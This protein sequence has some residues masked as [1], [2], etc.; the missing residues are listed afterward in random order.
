MAWQ[1]DL[2]PASFRGVPFKVENHSNTSG[3]RVTFHEFPNR[4]KPY[5]EDLGKVGE[6]FKIDGYLIGDDIKTQLENMKRAADAYGAAE[7]VHPRLGTLTVQCGPF[8]WEENKRDGRM[9]KISFQFYEGGSNAFPNSIEN[10]QDVLNDKADIA[11]AT[12]KASFD[13]K[14]SIDGLPGFAVD[15]ARKSVNQAADAF[16]N[17]TKGLAQKSDQISALAYNIRNLQAEADDLLQSPSALSQRLQDS[18]GLLQSALGSNKEAYQAVS[19]MSNFGTVTEPAPFQTPTRIAEA[20][21]LKAFDDFMKQTATINAA[22][23]A[24]VTEFDSVEESVTAREQIVES[25]E[26]QLLTTTDDDVFAAL[27]DVKAQVVRVLPDQDAELP[28]VQSYNLKATTPAIVV[29]YDLFENVDSE[30]DLI[31]RNKVRNPAFVLGGKELEVLDVRK[32][33]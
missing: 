27:E 4:D 20:Q 25:L 3:R 12:S 30:Q 8:T 7:L 33:A 2:R 14:F 11:L 6:T 16:T 17:A 1:D 9:I 22:K 32:R 19:V 5:P 18:F 15:T 23:I 29:A 24:S 21:N 31:N 26:A 28:N 10:K 13:K